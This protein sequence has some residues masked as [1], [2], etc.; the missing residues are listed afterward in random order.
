MTREECEKQILQKMKEINE[1]A[2]EYNPCNTYI[3]LC[4]H[5]GMVVQFW[6]NFW[7]TGNNEINYF[8]KIEDEE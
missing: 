5:G 1:I 4:I 3:T 2:K 7:D 6:N 8:G